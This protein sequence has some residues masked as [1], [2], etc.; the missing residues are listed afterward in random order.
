MHCVSAPQGSSP[1]QPPWRG[2]AGRGLGVTPHSCGG[3]VLPWPGVVVEGPLQWAPPRAGSGGKLHPAHHPPPNC[4]PRWAPGSRAGG[5]GSRPCV[6]VHVCP[7]L[8]STPVLT[9]AQALASGVRRVLPGTVGVDLG[10]VGSCSM[11]GGTG[12]SMGSCPTRGGGC[13]KVPAVPVGCKGCPQHSVGTGS[14]S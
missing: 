9:P 3:R 1:R 10:A 2:A 11:L 12:R 8:I 4:V 6:F 7:P 14:G 13:C 5:A